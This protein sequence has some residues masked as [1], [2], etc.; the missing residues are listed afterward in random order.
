MYI[1][2]QKFLSKK[3][4]LLPPYRL[5]NGSSCPLCPR[6]SGA[7][8][9]SLGWQ[10]CCTITYYSSLSRQLCCTTVYYSSLSWQPCCTILYYSSLGWQPCCTTAASVSREP[11]CTIRVWLKMHIV[12]HDVYLLLRSTCIWYKMSC[13]NVWKMKSNYSI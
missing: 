9:D 1:N 12:L 10:P 7:P 3:G 8:A 4:N 13:S 11:C 6:G 5:G 2:K